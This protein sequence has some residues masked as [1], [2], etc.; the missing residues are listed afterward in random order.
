MRKQTAGSCRGTTRRKSGDIY[1]YLKT[2]LSTQIPDDLASDIE[3]V[4]STCL[5]QH[6]NQK[7]K[8]QVYVCMIPED[9]FPTTASDINRG[10]QNPPP[11]LKSGTMYTIYLPRQTALAF[12]S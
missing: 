3:G 2:L 9:S 7:K 12:A 5:R 6:A 1:A 11:F 8:E 10:F 4:Y